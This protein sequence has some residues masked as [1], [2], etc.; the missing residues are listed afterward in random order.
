V[1]HESLNAE[2][3]F[4]TR[5]HAGWRTTQQG[6]RRRLGAS[7]KDT[8]TCTRN[9]HRLRPDT[10]IL[11][12]QGVGPRHATGVESPTI[13]ALAE[14]GTVLSGSCL[15]PIGWNSKN[16]AVGLIMQR[17]R[18]LWPLVRRVHQREA[19][20]ASLRALHRMQ[21][22]ALRQV[23]SLTSLGQLGN[24]KMK[25][26]A[27]RDSIAGLWKGPLRSVLQRRTLFIQTAATPNPNS[28]KFLPGSVVMENE[29][30]YDF[31]TPQAA[32]ASPLAD[33]L[34]QIDGVVG[35]MFGP[36]FITVTKREDIEWNVLRPEIFSVIMDFYMSGQPLFMDAS[37]GSADAPGL[38][39]DTRILDADPEHVA[40][41][42]ELIETR[43]RPAV[44]EDGGSVL[45]RGFEEATG[46]VLLEL[47]GACSS[48]ASSSVTLK[49][50]VE[51]MLRHYV[52]EVKAVREVKNAEREMMEAE[53]NR[54]L[55]ELER[56]FA[57]QHDATPAKR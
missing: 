33:K 52:P 49:N 45:Y 18:L 19:Q 14:T 5:W 20:L 25:G 3:R 22:E 43:I 24:Q 47:Q 27:R 42:K 40:M 38:N 21:P 36:D 11:G 37:T 31:P 8:A 54:M 48:C 7:E 41:I 32:R 13:N 46:T 17:V 35:V 9:R 51:N 6:T 56:R 30:T 16:Q 4:W 23:R 1:K 34:F 53:S 29:G 50:G 44:A 55:H 2:R 26:S 39:E 28:V 12:V 10:A 57:Q 15:Y